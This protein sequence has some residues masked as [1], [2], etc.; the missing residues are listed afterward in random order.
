MDA[1]SFTPERWLDASADLEHNLIAFPRGPRSCVG[2]NL[3]YAELYL[4]FAYMFRRFEIENA[5]TT[6]KDMEWNDYFVPYT[7]AHLKV[8][9]TPMSE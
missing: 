3:A 7:N 1:N 5:G 2:Q 9:L 4:A 8:K 6:A